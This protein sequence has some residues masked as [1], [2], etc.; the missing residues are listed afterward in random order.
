MTDAT[1]HATRYCAEQVQSQDEDRW[2]ACR[3]APAPL[4]RQLLALYAL[5]GELRRIPSV[6]S[7]P[8][9]GEIRL[10]WWRD[11]LDEIRAGKSPRVHPVVEEIAAADLA[12][13]DFGLLLNEAID[14]NARPLYGEA[15]ADASEL[16]GWLACA[17]GALDA[18]AVRLAGGDES[19]ATT[20]QLAGTGFSMAR[21]GRAL[22]PQFADS[23]GAR[24]LSIAEETA[25]ILK[26]AEASTA[27]ALLHLSLTRGYVR[28]ADKP[29]PISKRLRLFSAMAFG[30][31]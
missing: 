19:L 31:F 10:Q 21:E 17:D 11:A 23:V 22:A 15:F 24:A 4:R 14:A 27:P 8:P 13:S 26:K 25:P 28:R 6:V 20:A 3:Y 30:S 12:R 2:L 9:L 1:G 16:E 29:F 18:L 7:E 5:H